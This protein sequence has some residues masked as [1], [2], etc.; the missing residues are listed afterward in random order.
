MPMTKTVRARRRCADLV[1]TSVVATLALAGVAA[2]AAVRGN[3]A[4]PGWPN[5][6]DVGL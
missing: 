2:R 6:D 5:G 4:V 1:Q 3:V